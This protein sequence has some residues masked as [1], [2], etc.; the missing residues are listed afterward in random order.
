MAIQTMDLGGSFSQLSLSE[1]VVSK[2][3][4][5]S[6]II[7]TFNRVAMVVEAVESVL[8]QTYSPLEI[9]VIDDGSTD[10]TVQQLLSYGWRITLISK[11]R[12]QGV[13]AA[14]NLGIHQSHGDYVTL[15]DSDDLWLP[16]KIER[17]MDFF[18][19]HP[20]AL[21]CQTEEIWIRRGKRVNP[22]QKHRK[23]SGDI[24]P[25][26]LP[27][28]IVSPSAVMIKRELLS[29]V[30]LF[31]EQLPACED[32]DLWLRIAAHH[33]IFLLEEPLIIKRG[34]HEDQLSRTVLFLDRYRI[35]SLC[36]LLQKEELSATQRQ[37]VLTELQEKAR[38]FRNG[39]LKRGKIAE[40]EQ[41]DRMVTAVTGRPEG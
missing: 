8:D 4:L 13:S 14:R 5:V 30:G 15:L 11:V 2:K 12:N 25:H 7:P 17:Q 18:L 22:R 23:Y 33:P 24:F 21:I 6:V 20:E 38:I 27:L 1:L 28:C 26:C 10:D 37:Q 9:L 34:G 39:C 32:Y 40:A 29:Q 19:K 3:P 16:D 41:V 36:K 31:D 35:Q